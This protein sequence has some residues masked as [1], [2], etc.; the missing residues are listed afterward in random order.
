MTE[1]QKPKLESRFKSWREW[2]ILTT[3]EKVKV[4]PTLNVLEKGIIWCKEYMKIIPLQ[5]K[6]VSEVMTNNEYITD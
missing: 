2:A 6:A 4:Y 3:K 1:S 5:C